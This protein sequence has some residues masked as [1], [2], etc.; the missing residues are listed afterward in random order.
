M[1]TLSLLKMPGTYF[2][3]W[4]QREHELALSLVERKEG[5]SRYELSMQPAWDNGT[6]TW[7]SVEL[8]VSASP[9]CTWI[10][11]PLWA[12]LSSLPRDVSVPSRDPCGW[13]S[14]RL[15]LCYLPPEKS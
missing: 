14:R 7:A 2:S 11:L 8:G 15:D 3:A 12:A 5:V 13:S 4:G 10:Q 1:V 9:G 6:G